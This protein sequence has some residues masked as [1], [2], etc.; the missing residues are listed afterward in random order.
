MKWT[1][2]VVNST[3]HCGRKFAFNMFNNLNLLIRSFICSIYLIFITYLCKFIQHAFKR[4]DGPF[5]RKNSWKQRKRTYKLRKNLLGI[6]L[7]E[8]QSLQVFTRIRNNYHK[9][10][11]NIVETLKMTMSTQNQ[12]C[13]K[14]SPAGKGEV[15]A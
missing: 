12:A 4:H 8:Y 2:A 15:T 1:I 13:I 10:K 6:I 3:V 11:K 5:I 9:D 7:S 14:Q